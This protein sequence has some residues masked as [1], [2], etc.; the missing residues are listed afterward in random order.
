MKLKVEEKIIAPKE[1]I[2]GDPDAKVLIVEYGDYESSETAKNNAVVN[3][4]LEKYKGKIKYNFR[5]FPMT[6]IHQRSFKAAEAA[7]G[8]AQEGKFWE[9]H[10]TLLQHQRNLGTIS[11]KGYARDVG[12]TAK[13]FLDDLMNSKFGWYVRDDQAQAVDAGVTEVPAIFINGERFEGKATPQGLSVAIE[14]ALK[15]RKKSQRA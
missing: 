4:L 1:V 7:I 9:M 3:Q 12:V 8:A 14:A 2:V 5:H 15:S 6:K 11:L 10:N 13:S